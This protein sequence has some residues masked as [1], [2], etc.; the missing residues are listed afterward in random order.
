M[1]I[2]YIYES[3]FGR[4][5]AVVWLA[6][7]LTGAAS[8]STNIIYGTGQGVDPTT[9]F[10]VDPHWQIVALPVSFTN[11]AAPFSA[12]NPQPSGLPGLWTNR[13]GYT[14]SGVTNYWMA[15]NTTGNTLE[16]LGTNSYN[17]IAAQ[18]FIISQAGVYDFDFGGTA[19]NVMSFFVNGSV[20]GTATDFPTIT[21]GTQIGATTTNPPGFRTMWTFSG[22]AYLEA[23]TNT[24]FM[25]LN[26]Y[27]GYTGALIAQSTFEIIPEPSTYALV[28][29]GAGALCAWQ[30]R[31]GLRRG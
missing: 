23:G 28:L 20:S 29:L 8:A 9:G 1:H 14:N 5:A 26:D 19:D 31:K 27:G 6:C 17:W 12:Y 11:Q 30:R 10:T 4:M 25:V 15:P 18:T 7:L 2:A 22:Q 21:G 13:F 3:V 16:G 24:A